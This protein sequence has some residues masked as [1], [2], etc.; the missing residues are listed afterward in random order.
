MIFIYLKSV[1]NRKVSAL[2]SAT[3]H[4]Q[5]VTHKQKTEH[6]MNIDF[7]EKQKF[8]QWWLWIILIGIGIIPIIGLYKQLILKQIF[9][10]NP[11]SDFGLIVFSFFIFLIIGIFFLITLETRITNEGI[12]MKFIP[13]VQKRI[14]WDEIKNAELVKY[15]FSGFG[16]RISLKYGTIYNIKGKNG[17]FIEL[18][19][20]E[21]ILIGTQKQNE[22]KKIVNK[23]LE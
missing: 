4:I 18:K 9:G 14:R 20:G 2:K 21:K 12:Q 22:L 10:D 13:F 6:K 8:S 1:I 17:L 3:F 19:N 7:K 5:T 11:M 16:I 15:G 23:Y